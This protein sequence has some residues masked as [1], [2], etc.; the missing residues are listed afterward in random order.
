MLE[1]SRS[2]CA[3]VAGILDHAPI[4]DLPRPPQS[5]LQSFGEPTH[6]WNLLLHL[7]LACSESPWLAGDHRRESARRSYFR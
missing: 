4:C 7:G 3:D 5:S 6:L 1:S 2:L